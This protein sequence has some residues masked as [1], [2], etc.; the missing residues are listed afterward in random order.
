MET[1]FRAS[2]KRIARPRCSSATPFQRRARV[3]V[4][5]AFSGTLYSSFVFR[6][7]LNL[8]SAMQERF[9]NASLFVALWGFL[10]MFRKDS[11]SASVRMED[12]ETPLQRLV[13]LLARKYC[14]SSQIRSLENAR[15]NAA[16]QDISETLF[17]GLVLHSAR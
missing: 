13:L 1:R 17:L 3:C 5:R 4:R 15:L 2:V 16:L 6:S 10:V 9:E 11:V 14:R 7:V 8:F 12:S